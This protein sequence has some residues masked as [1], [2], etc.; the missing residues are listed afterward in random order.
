VTQ[1]EQ[2]QWPIDGHPIF[3]RGALAS[4]E[5]ELPQYLITVQAARADA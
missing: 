4:T 5:S 3:M 1:P 2:K